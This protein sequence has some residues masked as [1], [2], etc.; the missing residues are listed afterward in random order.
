[1][2]A[3]EGESAA[4]G[5]PRRYRRM[6]VVVEVHSMED[7]LEVVRRAQAWGD[8]SWRYEKRRVAETR[9][10]AR[11]SR[12]HSIFTMKALLLA[13]WSAAGTAWELELVVS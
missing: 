7:I 8:D 9:V 12:S 5:F 11:S 1:M 13:E 3:A 10:N 4:K 6:V 2:W